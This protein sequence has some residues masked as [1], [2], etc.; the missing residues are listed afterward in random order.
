MSKNW[1]QEYINHIREHRPKF[2]RELEESSELDNVAQ[3]VHESA[4]EVYQKLVDQSLEQGMNLV[5]AE[6]SATSEVMRLYILLPTEK[7]VPNLDKDTGSLPEESIQD[8]DEGHLRVIQ[9]IQDYENQ[10]EENEE[11]QFFSNRTE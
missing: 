10:V 1:K 6:A 11:D 2:F 5:I 4:S 3:S 7:D 9:D 8:L